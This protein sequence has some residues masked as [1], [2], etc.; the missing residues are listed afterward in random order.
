MW[1]RR[2]VSALPSAVHDFASPLPTKTADDVYCCSTVDH[3]FCMPGRISSSESSLGSPLGCRRFRPYIFRT[4]VGR[5]SF[6]VDTVDAGA[7]SVDD[8][9]VDAGRER[10]VDDDRSVASASASPSLSLCELDTHRY[11]T[12][13]FDRQVDDGFKVRS[14]LRSLS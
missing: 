9:R 5:N 13:R 14:S 12:R 6:D 2:N 8:D 11:V 1:C 4:D 7:L 3:D 10:R